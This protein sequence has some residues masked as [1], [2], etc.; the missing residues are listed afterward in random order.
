MWLYPHRDNVR[1]AGGRVIA[2]R[3]A[4]REGVRTSTCYILVYRTNKVE[5]ASE[6][7]QIKRMPGLVLHVPAA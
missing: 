4:L 6:C 3:R 2:F 5:Y 7:G 1:L